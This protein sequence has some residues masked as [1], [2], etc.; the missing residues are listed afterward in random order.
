MTN[1]YFFIFLACFIFLNIAVLYTYFFLND[2]QT[3]EKVHNDHFTPVLPAAYPIQA[4]S[5]I[6]GAF[7]FFYFSHDKT[8]FYE[9]RFLYFLGLL[10]L[11]GALGLLPQKSKIST[12]I[13]SVL[14]LSAITGFVFLF[15]E[16][17]LPVKSPSGYIP[18]QALLGLAWFVL[19]KFTDVLSDR[20][21]GLFVIQSIHMGFGTLVVLLLLPFSPISWLQ[22]NVMLLPLMLF[23]VPLYCVFETELPLKRSIRNIFSLLLTGLAFL[24]VPTGNWGLGVLMS[25]YIIF[26]LVIVILTFLSNIPKKNKKPLFFYETIMEKASSEENVVRIIMHYNFL[27]DGLIFFLV[28]MNAQLQLVVA[29]ALLYLKMY[30]NIINPDSGRSGVL[31]L[32]KDAKK[33][34]KIGIMESSKAFSDLKRAYSRKKEPQNEGKS[35][36]DPS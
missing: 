21:E 17:N 2:T 18:V 6:I 27:T 20:F 24:A 13:C 29:T 25:S 31:D 8:W 19:Y 9:T 16:N 23:M 12:V 1:L 34:A 11:I 28:Y 22:I 14:E 10:P 35:E 5:F 4:F 33:T 15:P 7:F 3:N 30:L 36:N 32:F 26:E